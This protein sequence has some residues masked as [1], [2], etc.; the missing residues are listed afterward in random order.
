MRLLLRMTRATSCTLSDLA[1]DR[2]L[3]KLCVPA[4]RS[5]AVRLYL[6]GLSLRLDD[7]RFEHR[8]FKGVVTTEPLFDQAIA[9][10]CLSEAVA[11]AQNNECP[12]CPVKILCSHVYRFSYPHA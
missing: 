3:L 2:F 10:E 12:L 6:L 11:L 5:T 9:S 7:L 4:W 8:D 1:C